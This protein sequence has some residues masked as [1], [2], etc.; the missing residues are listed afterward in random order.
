[1]R[2][3]IAKDPQNSKWQHGYVVASLLKLEAQVQ[4]GRI[5]QARETLAQAAPLAAAL[6]AQD[7]AN[8]TW[9]LSLGRSHWWR[10]QLDAASDGAAATHAARAASEIL[11]RAH[12]AASE[13]QNIA[14]W[15]LRA[16]AMRA[17]LAL[18]AGDTAAAALELARG[19]R[20]ADAVG[21]EAHTEQLRPWLAEHLL[22]Q[23]ELEAGRGNA[24][25][26]THAWAEARRL[27][28]QVSGDDGEL[29]EDTGAIPFARLDALLRAEIALGHG[30]QATPIR[31]RLD[32]AGYVPPRP[33]PIA[34]A[35]AA[36]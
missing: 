24:A 4:R 2:T 26:A 23:G 1:L 25:A 16:L 27:L 15:L 32:A 3:N 19:A 35:L 10:A 5:A 9:R 8:N 34:A 18:D 28:R 6:H 29:H 30:Q 14:A 31:R 12:A 13:D 20:V 36:R 11:A 33:F 21:K 7:D 17:R 22:L